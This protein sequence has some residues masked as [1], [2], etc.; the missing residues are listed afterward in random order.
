MLVL[1]GAD[2]ASVLDRDALVEAV[3][4]ALAESSAGRSSVPPRIAAVVPE[5]QV[6]KVK[7]GQPARVYLDSDPAKAIEASVQRIDPQC[8]RAGPFVPDRLVGAGHPLL[9]GRDRR[10]PLPFPA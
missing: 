3:A 8:A 4:T 10:C 6:G 9:P 2:V 7:V 1:N 5:G